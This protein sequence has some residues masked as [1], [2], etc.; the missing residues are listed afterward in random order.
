MD[1][2]GLAQVSVTKRY[3]HSTSE[4]TTMI[5]DQVGG[6]D[7]SLPT[8]LTEVMVGRQDRV[9]HVRSPLYP[10]T[11]MTMLTFEYDC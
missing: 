8:P 7:W 2:R 6:L 10:R 4:L 3:Q 11:S 1:V 9:V 5:V